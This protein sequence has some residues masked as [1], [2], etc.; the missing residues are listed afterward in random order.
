MLQLNI[1]K[2]VSYLSTQRRVG[3]TKM[4]DYYFEETVVKRYCI[5]AESED[6]ARM[7]VGWQHQYEEK[8]KDWELVEV[9]E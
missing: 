8:S 7:M 3:E 1:N 5:T 2:V 9:V 6:E 4:A